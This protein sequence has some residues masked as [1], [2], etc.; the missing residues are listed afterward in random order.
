MT[1]YDNPRPTQHHDPLGPGTPPPDS[2]RRRIIIAAVSAAAVVAI[3]LPIAFRGGDVF[4]GG[5][6]SSPQPATGSTAGSSAPSSAP[7]A[8]DSPGT[9]P[10]AGV[11]DVSD[12]PT[13]DAPHLEYVTGGRVLHEVDGS[14]V[15]IA[16]RYRVNSFV[17]LADGSHL[18]LTATPDGTPYVEAQDAAGYM[19]EPV[20]SSWSLSVNSAHT[21]GAWVRPDGQVMAWNAGAAHALE[22]GDPVPASSEPRMGPLLG[23]RCGPGGTCEIYLNLSDRQAESGWQPWEVSVNG[24]AKLLDGDFRILADSTESGLS[25]GYRSISDTGSC[26]VLLG[27]GEFQGFST[28]KHTLESFSPDGRLI[29]GVPAYR[30]GIGDGVIAMYDLEGKLLFERRNTLKTESFY[31]SAQWED[32]THVLAPVFQHQTW[33]LVRFASD[34]SMEYAVAPVAGQ[35]LE[36]PYVIATGGPVLGG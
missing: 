23:D 24:T 36:N 29:L 34:G 13:G 1:S 17:A 35:D 22:Y 25:I 14:T 18:W 31:S 12:L 33:S 4:G 5:D 9:Q 32:A 21:V 28:C 10:A 2:R 11:L 8:T 30:D 6:Q 7:T 27:G 15:D 20:R 19:L 3:T 26:S 16:T